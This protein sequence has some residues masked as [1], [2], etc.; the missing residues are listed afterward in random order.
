M[1]GLPVKFPVKLHRNSLHSTL[2]RFARLLTLMAA[3]FWGTLAFAQ[4]PM[5]EEGNPL[6][7]AEAIEKENPTFFVHAATDG[8]TLEF[9]DGEQLRIKVRCEVDAYLYAIYTQADQKSYVVLPNSGSSKQ[10]TPAKQEVRIPG[11][12][13]NFRWSV[14]APF[15]KESLKVIACRQRIEALEKPEM[16]RGQAAALSD[17]DLAKLIAEI[18][19]KIPK[20]DWSEVSL[21]LTTHE[22]INPKSP[23]FGKRYGVFFGVH[24][25]DGTLAAQAC[26]KKGQPRPVAGNL[27]P[28]AVFD[29]HMLHRALR[30]S[31]SLDDAR[32]FPNP[33]NQAT[34]GATRDNMEQAITQWLPSVTKPG[35]TVVIFFSGHGAVMEDAP[36]GKQSYLVPSDFLEAFA[37]LAMRKLRDEGRA[38]DSSTRLLERAEQIMREENLTL[39]FT[40]DQFWAASGEQMNAYLK[41]AERVDKRLNLRSCI[42]ENEFEHW[43][44][45]LP[46]RRI[47]FITDAC[48]SGGF[49]PGDGAG[50]T[51]RG[52]VRKVP[53]PGE[54][55]F[56]RQPSA[57]L[58]DLGQENTS[59]IV[60]A[61]VDESGLGNI[62]VD[63]GEEA[64]AFQMYR[65]VF[66]DV[67]PKFGYKAELP[68]DGDAV[69][70]FSYFLVNALLSTQGT[71]DVE[72]A[73]HATAEGM[74]R[75]FAS[76]LF[77]TQVAK[78]KEE[79]K[80]ELKPHQ[81]VWFDHCRPKALLKP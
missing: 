38:T 34:T 62:K 69:A 47:V 36:G 58:K 28:V 26:L 5:P 60:A 72:Q 80:S 45:K 15:G 7:G 32:F 33:D 9:W 46:G 49:A 1:V 57:R 31:G 6:V 75:Y 61:R 18:K 81:P 24:E 67:A 27:G 30:R 63:S 19:T 25:H 21:A 52:F 20:N 22:G 59:M 35:D 56:L 14:S 48:N 71:M 78:I 51:T 77:R 37:V 64:P 79:S 13:D 11:D 39:S 16:R 12:K 68:K 53:N 29:G 66:M 76:E 42:L 8:G 55:Q 73:G 10:K 3:A 70:V 50:A 4:K 54:F 44:Q 2:E 40:W 41:E 74:K 23:H 43:L 65:D 17:Q